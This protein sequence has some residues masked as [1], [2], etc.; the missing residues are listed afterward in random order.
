MTARLQRQVVYD[1]WA[2]WPQKQRKDAVIKF[3]LKQYEALHLPKYI[4]ANIK[5]SSRSFCQKIEE[6]WKKAGKHKNI[7]LSKN[8]NWLNGDFRLSVIASNFLLDKNV[9]KITSRR[10]RPELKFEECGSRTQKKKI[11]NLVSSTSKD[12]LLVA[13]EVKLRNDG[14]RDAA[15][16]VKKIASSPTKGTILKKAYAAYNQKPEDLTSDQALAMMVDAQLSTHQYNVIRNQVKSLNTRKRLY[17]PYYKV[18][19][20]KRKC[21]P[22]DIDINETYAE[23]K[24]QSLIDHT[25]IRLYEAQKDVFATCP[26]SLENQNLKLV[27]KWGCDG[28]DQHRY[29]QKFNQQGASDENMFSISMVPIQLYCENGTSKTIFWQNPA[30]SS[31]RYCRPIKFVYAKET[32]ELT[33]NEVKKIEDQAEK[34]LPTEITVNGLKVS[35]TTTMIL[36]MIDGKVCNCLA[37]NSST[38]T[39]YICKAKPKD[40]N[41]PDAI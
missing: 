22:S 21:Y 2:T 6:K 15:M 14:N 41:S 1:V 27:V 25:I 18:R 16:L 4:E 7:F 35:V 28:A 23:I 31:T 5:V 24:L 19:E 32:V 3:I 9:P 13:A 30:P 29:R 39:C 33:K 17:P 10:G 37:S 11:R 20:A 36:C 12:Q 38:L 26:F 8:A 40:M 34:L